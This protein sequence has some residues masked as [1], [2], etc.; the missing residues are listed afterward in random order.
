M[1]GNWKLN[2]IKCKSLLEVLG[3]WGW[4]PRATKGL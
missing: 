2:K 3:H 1:F 4:I